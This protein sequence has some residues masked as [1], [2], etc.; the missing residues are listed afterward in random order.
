MAWDPGCCWQLIQRARGGVKQATY[1]VAFSPVPVAGIASQLQNSCPLCYMHFIM[2]P[3]PACQACYRVAID[4]SRMPTFVSSELFQ[5][6]QTHGPCSNP[7]AQPLLCELRLCRPLPKFVQ[8]HH[9][10]QS[11][12]S[13]PMRRVTVGLLVQIK[14]SR[15]GEQSAPSHTLPLPGHRH[16]L[17][18][19]SDAR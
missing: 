2:E 11:Q 12:L 10:L 17:C 4:L 9:C 16:I 6:L 5:A 18:Q 19:S 15:N 3:L 8:D 7:G 13:G 1:P 14:I